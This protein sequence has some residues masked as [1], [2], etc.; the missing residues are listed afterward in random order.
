MP[1]NL[2]DGEFIYEP[3]IAYDKIFK[4]EHHKNVVDFFE[5]LVKKSKLDKEANRLA[6]KELVSLDKRRNSV[7]KKIN[8]NKFLKGFLIFLMVIFVILFG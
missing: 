4:K 1:E 7:Q 8:N 6:N 3:L 5:E 2:Y